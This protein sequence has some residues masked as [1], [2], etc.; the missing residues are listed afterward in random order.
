MKLPDYWRYRVW[1]YWADF[2]HWCGYITLPH[3]VIRARLWDWC[4]Y[5]NGQGKHL[6]LTQRSWHEIWRSEFNRYKY[7]EY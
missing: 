6:N 2:G 4:H 7:G 5:Q 3:K 1:T